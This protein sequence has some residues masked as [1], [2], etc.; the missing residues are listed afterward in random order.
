M[1]TFHILCLFGTHFNPQTSN[2]ISFIDPEKHSS[3][4][5][6]AQ[7]G[8]MIIYDK[9]ATLSSHETFNILRVEFITT[10][11]NTNTREV[12][13]VIT[14]YKPSILLFSTFT[15]Q[16]QTLLVVMPTYCPTIIM[17]DFNIDMFDQN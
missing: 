6:Y 3:I 11:F 15:N 1:K 4:N 16:L 5:V 17:G 13:H 2:I 7:N 14:I 8:T 12:I 9:F 10:T